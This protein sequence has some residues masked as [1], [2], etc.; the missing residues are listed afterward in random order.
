MRTDVL[1]GEFIQEVETLGKGWALT[2]AEN[3]TFIA[4]EVEAAVQT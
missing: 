4:R 1:K 2:A 3:E